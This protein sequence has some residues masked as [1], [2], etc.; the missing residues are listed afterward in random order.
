M[1][2]DDNDYFS[3]IKNGKPFHS[4]ET[5]ELILA[6]LDT[7]IRVT[8]AEYA[9][10]RVFLHAGVVAWKGKA[11]IIPGKSFQGKSTLVSALVEKGALYFSDEYAVLDKKGFVHPFPKMLSLRGVVDDFRQI[12]MAVETIGGK[13][14]KKEL[15]VGMVLLTEYNAE[16]VWKPIQLTMGEG[17]MELLPHTIPIR[18]N[19]EFSLNVL[20]KLV[21]RAIIS[22]TQR[23]EAGIFA[24]IILNFF[25]TQAF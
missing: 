8:I 2:L 5:L 25:E 4:S 14:S 18:N 1:K 22:K 10:E 20:N 15:P 12:D 21:N 3:I 9:V 13:A 24:E 11:I 7:K 16:A 23:G 19:P 17:I 6:H